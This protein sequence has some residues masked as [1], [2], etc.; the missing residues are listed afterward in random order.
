MLRRVLIAAVALEL[1]ASTAATAA[2]EPS[3]TQEYDRGIALYL[4]GNYAASVRAFSRSYAIE[5]R[6]ETLFAWAQAE[7]LQGNCPKAIELYDRYLTQD[8]PA[9]QV[10]IVREHLARCRSVILSPW[11]TDVP[12]DILVGTGAVGLVAGTWF[13]ASSVRTRNER[14][15][16]TTDADYLRLAKEARRERIVGL[17]ALGAGAAA[18]TAGIIRFVTRSPPGAPPESGAP[19]VVGFAGTTA[20]GLGVELDF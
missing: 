15:A 3:A 9:A 14:D 17:V 2:P 16:A 20:A 13:L 8:P 12:G 6:R 7:R 11:Y 5:P 4:D 18:V 19:R 10:P 1:A